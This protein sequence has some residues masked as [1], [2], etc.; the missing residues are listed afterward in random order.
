MLNHTLSS[1]PID[2]HDPW[3][4]PYKVIDDLFEISL[5]RCSGDVRGALSTLRD[6]DYL[7]VSMRDKSFVDSIPYLSNE[8][9]STL[10]SGQL[11]RY[12][13]LVQDMYGAEMYAGA[14]GDIDRTGISRKARISKYRDVQ[15]TDYPDLLRHQEDGYQNDCYMDRYFFSRVS[16]S[17]FSSIHAIKHCQWFDRNFERIIFKLIT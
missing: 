1:M 13:G 4:S 12:R 15:R 7:E 8:T 9:A 16:L 10:Q 5:S 17:L 14:I 3:S 6:V 2:P 11:C